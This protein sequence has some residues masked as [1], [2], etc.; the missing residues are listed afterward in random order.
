MPALPLVGRE[1]ELA[2]LHRLLDDATAGRGRMLLL[3]GESGVGKSRLAKAA[4]DEAARR[5]LHVAVGRGYPVEVGIPYAPISDALLPLL[6]ALSAESLAVLTRGGEAELFSLFPALRPPDSAVR[7]PAADPSEFKTRLLWNFSQFL[8]R[9]AAK[10][11]LLLLIDD[12][13]WADP[14]SL[15]LLHFVARQIAGER[16]ALLC[17]YNTAQRE[18]NPTLRLT[19]QSLISLNAAA[20]HEVQPLS[21]ADTDRLIREAFGQEDAVTREFAALLYGWTRGNP[22]FVEQVLKSLV[23]TGRLYRREGSWLGWELE[24]IQLPRSI[25][26]VLLERAAQLGPDA[27]ALA[28]LHAVVGT[29]AS[30]ETLHTVSAQDEVRFVEALDELRRA[31]I[32]VE[33]LSG[34]ELVYDFSHPALWETLYSELGL[35]RTRLLHGTVAEALERRAAEGGTENPDELAYHFARAG[36]RHL[37]PKAMR[38]LAAAGRNALQR[39]AYRE[40]AD[41]LGAALELMDQTGGEVVPDHSVVEDLARARQRLGDY[42]GAI[43]LWERCRGAAEQRRDLAELAAI[44]HRIGLALHWS[45]RSEAALAHYDA[46]LRAAEAAASERA[47]ARLKLAKGGCLQEIGRPADAA[48]ELRSALA[49]AEQQQDL[50]LQSQIHRVLLLLHTWMGPPEVAR[51]HGAHSLEISQRT[52]DV[53]LACSTHWAL[54]VLEGLTGNL[55]SMAGHIRRSEQ[56]ADEIRSPLHRL[57]IAEVAI[58]HLAAT[59]EWDTA[60]TLAERSIA[61]AR[62]F[63]QKHLLPRLLVWTSLLYLARGDLERGH[64]YVDEAWAVAGADGQEGTLDVH[65]VVPAHTGRAAYHLALGEYAEAARIG[66]AGL[67]IADRTGYT[68]WAIHRLLP[69]ICEAYLWM[70]DF[71]NARRQGERLRRDAERLGHKAGIAWAD[72]C[73]AILEWLQGD[74]HRGVELL[75]QAAERLEAIPVI[76]DAARIRRHYAARLRDLGDRDGA[77]RQLRQIHDVFVHLGAEREL[78]KTREQI[79]ELGARPPAREAGAAGAGGLTAR[80]IEIVRLIARR[81]SNK[82]IGQALDISARTVSTHLSHIF[83]KLEVSSRGELAEVARQLEL[84]E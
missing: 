62:T 48:A 42:A 20:V 54:A 51:Q 24:E 63:H 74:V 82:A 77:L 72:A 2:T 83:R 21:R 38:Y 44:E 53:A 31:Q 71:E 75:R 49:L 39:Y 65:S 57:W 34:D 64:S 26:E 76:S 37:A 4:A 68:A 52:G 36:G 59:G 19:E 18:R 23:Q 13:Q 73:D 55:T 32:T 67:E 27:R 10:Q 8:A 61:Q 28:D 11:P 9:L 30:Y 46:G 79:R 25:R 69:I 43:E 47:R 15:E 78:Q 40:A 29:S 33:R 35:A 22:F 7:A 1:T 12:L 6:R 58:E 81:R 50:P 70:F 84:P 80:E 60:L 45:G 41:Y 56:L 17:T 3:V 16:I 14:S 5:K 66:E